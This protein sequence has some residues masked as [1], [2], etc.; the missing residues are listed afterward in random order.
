MVETIL[1]PTDGSE[2]SR[3]A[4]DHAVRLA[5]PLDASI[6]ALS[7]AS[8]YASGQRQDQ[9][10]SDPEDE[11]R[12]ALAE[13]EDAAQRANV[14]FTGAVREGVTHEEILESVDAHDIDM[15]VMGTHG[16]SGLKRAL[17]GSVAEKTLRNSPVPVLAVPQSE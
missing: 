13:A 8:E 10:R 2:H 4:L 17:S 9:L 11:A 5:Q 3:K 1:L 12:D 15:I 7:I 16:R 14:E 6:H